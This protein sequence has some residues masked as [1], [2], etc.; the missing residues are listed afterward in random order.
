MGI[1]LSQICPD[2]ENGLPISPADIGAQAPPC[3]AFQ[4][5]S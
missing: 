4:T 2:D 5:V 1:R 3:M